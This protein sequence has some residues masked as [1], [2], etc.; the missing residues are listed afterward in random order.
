M[1]DLDTLGIT[2]YTRLYADENGKSHFEDVYVE[3]EP[4]RCCDLSRKVSSST[5]MKSGGCRFLS[6]PAG[7]IS[8]WHLPD[9]KCLKIVL[10]GQWEVKAGSGEKRLFENGSAIMIEDTNGTGHKCRVLGRNNA[11][12][13]VVEMGLGVKENTYVFLR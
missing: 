7:W 5:L 1:C 12:F 4:M 13:L 8:E 3:L 2:K 9:G 11:L 6:V 10:S